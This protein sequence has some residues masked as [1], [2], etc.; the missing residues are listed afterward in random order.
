MAENAIEEIAGNMIENQPTV[1]EHLDEIRKEDEKTEVEITQDIQNEFSRN[2]PIISNPVVND[3]LTFDPNIHAIDGA[4]NPVK[5]KDGIHYARKRGR[6]TGS[7]VN[8]QSTNGQMVG[9]ERIATRKAAEAM[10]GLFVTSSMAIFGEEWKPKVDKDTNESEILISAFEEYFATTGA[11]N[12]PPWAGLCIAI[13]FYSAPRLV[14]PKT[15][16]RIAKISE[17]IAGMFSWFRRKK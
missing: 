12:V 13:G 14:M 5:K 10:A 16:S 1:S 4:G 17:K 6:K 8:T 7:T 2:P 15:R 9:T 11:I 3:D